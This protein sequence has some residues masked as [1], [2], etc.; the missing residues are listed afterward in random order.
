MSDETL[1]PGI[2][3]NFPTL[4]NS[5][6]R[7]IGRFFLRRF[8][9][10]VTGAFPETNRF[11]AAVAPHTSN[12][13]F[14]VGLAAMFALGFRGHWLGKKSMFVWPIG[15]L[16]RALG[17]IPVDRA[18]P[19]GIVGQIAERFDTGEPLILAVAPE[20]TR[21][22]VAKLKTG[23]I[24][25][26]IAARVPIFLIAFDYGP[27]EINLGKLFYPTGDLDVDEQFIRDYFREFQGKYP[28]QYCP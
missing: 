11:I 23:F 10:R 5:V 13:D 4:G 3:E 21:R 28:D 15:W 25:I 8:G 16:M 20:G 7:A 22:R 1:V 19:T 14:P 12:W 27:R 24:R 6:T 17:G 26:A 2:P 9:W 18:A